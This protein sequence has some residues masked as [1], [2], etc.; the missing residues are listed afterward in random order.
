MTIGYLL[1]RKISKNLTCGLTTY[2]PFVADLISRECSNSLVMDSM[3]LAGLGNDDVDIITSLFTGCK[4][5]SFQ[6]N[7]NCIVVNI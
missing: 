4:I 6:F 1:I 3:V 2:C 5:T 7:L